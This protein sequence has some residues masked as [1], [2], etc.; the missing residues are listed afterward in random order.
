MGEILLL[1][2]EVL[3]ARPLLGLFQALMGVLYPTRTPHLRRRQ[4]ITLSVL[5]TVCILVATLLLEMLLGAP[6]V[7]KLATFGAIVAL[8]YMAGFLGYW[9]E[10][11]AR[12]P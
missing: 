10:K 6:F 9:I 2:V 4:W 1:C 5:L 8:A 12:H 7:A 11:E 3:L